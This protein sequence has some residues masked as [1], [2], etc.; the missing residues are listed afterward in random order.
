MEF[1]IYIIL[2][3]CLQH[4]ALGQN[5]KSQALLVVILPL[6]GAGL[7]F[8]FCVFLGDTCQLSG[9]EKGKCVLID[10]C[11]YAQDLLK[12]RI[13]P[14]I[15]RF[16]GQSPVVCCKVEKKLQLNLKPGALSAASECFFIYSKV[17]FSEHSNLKNKFKQKYG[18]KFQKN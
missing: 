15:C 18:Y 14:R 2:V 3:L 8:F 11:P 13:F 17:T 16:Q 9:D 4:F 12:R 5:G 1:F 6:T 7:R 10:K